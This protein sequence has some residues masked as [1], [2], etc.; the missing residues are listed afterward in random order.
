M[1]QGQYEQQLE[2]FAQ[3]SSILNSR[4]PGEFLCYMRFNQLSQL[5]SFWRDYQS[6]ALRKYLTQALLDTSTPSFFQDERSVSEVSSSS[7][8]RTAQTSVPDWLSTEL[9][10]ECPFDE[11]P[12]N[13][14]AESLKEIRLQISRPSGTGFAVPQQMGPQVVPPGQPV[15]LPFAEQLNPERL[16]L[17]LYISQRE[18]E[19]GR[20]LLMRNLRDTPSMSRLISASSYLPALMP[21]M[22]DPS[23]TQI[24]KTSSS[25]T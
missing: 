6:G 25:T 21:Q 2:I 11:H 18:Y 13:V 22:L 19:N 23:S 3:A 24:N 17:H 12:F 14:L 10:E 15:Q 16:S 4:S 20:F 7:A 5:E 1:R 8:N 9:S